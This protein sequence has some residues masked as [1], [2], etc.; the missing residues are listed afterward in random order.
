MFIHTCYRH[1]HILWKEEWQC[2][3]VVNNVLGN[4]TI[5]RAIG[6]WYFDRNCFQQ[7][8]TCDV[9]QKCTSTLDFDAFNKK[10]I[11]NC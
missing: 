7:I 6:D 1:G 3:C 8:D 10:C 4:K 11:Q 2:S 5:A 9:P